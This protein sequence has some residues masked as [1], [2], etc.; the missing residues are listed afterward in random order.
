MAETIEFMK[1]ILNTISV[2]NISI[3]NFNK[4]MRTIQGIRVSF[5]GD[6]KEGMDS[7]EYR[8]M[9]YIKLSS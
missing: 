7:L 5:D 1:E 9:T 8:L 2:L 6:D 3:Y 4:M